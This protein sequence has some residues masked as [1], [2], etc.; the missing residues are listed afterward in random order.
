MR[1]TKQHVEY[2][3]TWMLV[4]IAALCTGCA[5]KPATTHS[6]AEFVD[7]G[8]RIVIDSRGGARVDI[9]GHLGRLGGE[10]V[11]HTVYVPCEPDEATRFIRT[12]HA[13]IEHSVMAPRS[14]F[15]QEY[16]W[17]RG[18]RLADEISF[19]FR[20]QTG[21]TVRS[22]RVPWTGVD[23]NLVLKG[24]IDEAETIA[25]YDLASS[26]A[27]LAWA[28]KLAKRGQRD[29]AVHR[30]EYA[31]RSADDWYKLM[32]VRAPMMVHSHQERRFISV[33]QSDPKEFEQWANAID[34][35]VSAQK[36]LKLADRD[37]SKWFF[38]KSHNVLPEPLIMFVPDANT[39]PTRDTSRWRELFHRNEWNEL[40]GD[41]VILQRHGDVTTVRFTRKAFGA[42]GRTMYP[43]E[44]I[45]SDCLEFL[46]AAVWK[47]SKKLIDWY[48][49]TQNGSE[50]APG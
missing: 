44:A 38:F 24:L 6:W 17:G 47:K 20:C 32:C 23:V 34:R 3:R 5:S 18:H 29:D 35:R 43:P 41:M 37:V 31:W 45:P 10:T 33:P 25:H 16:F 15:G 49:G 13:L 39:E 40:I 50:K 7:A 9:L 4:G 19:Q 1:L 11:S 42:H 46:K 48:G 28:E 27:D 2:G 8:R 21:P 14:S 26:V 36:A 22:T 30:W 12:M